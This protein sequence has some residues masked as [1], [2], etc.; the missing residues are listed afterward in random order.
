MTSSRRNL[1]WLGVGLLVLVF[2]YAVRGILT[3]FVAGIALAYLLDPVVDR[4][5]PRLGRS[6]ASAL[7]LILFFLAFI[8]VL[9]AMAPI[10]TDQLGH[11]MAT[12]PAEF[13]RVEQRVLA[14]LQQ[15]GGVER[16][17]EVLSGS[18]GK[19]VEWVTTQISGLIAGGFAFFGVLGLILISPV[20]AFY[21]V[22]DYDRIVAEVDRYIPPRYEPIVRRLMRE[23]DQAL[24]GF[25]RGQVLVC[26]G[27][28]FIYAVLWSLIGLN[29]SLLLG[30][31]AGLLAFIPYVG[32]ATGAVLALLTGF[33][34]F[35]PDPVMLGLT[36]GVYGVAQ[37]AES[38]VLVP[39]L[40]GDQ[41]GLHAVW[42]LFA[43][44]AGGSLMGFVGV[45]IAVPV[46]AVVAVVARWM[47]SEFLKGSLYRASDTPPVEPPAP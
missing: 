26:L 17:R 18:S 40:M 8:L 19:V 16:A 38:A 21:L 43:V 41:V 15:A 25:I 23:A 33:G 44:L 14:L 42:V 22:R 24:A 10:L 30:L 4:L 28:A 12:L 5:E 45:L 20:V 11:L 34:Q 29:Y 37:M 47:L 39:K 27:L 13:A 2:L 46:A 1:I 9:L 31:I 32:Q 7:V 36:A 35:G 3:P 6:M